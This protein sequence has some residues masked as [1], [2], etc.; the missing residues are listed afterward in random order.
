MRAVSVSRRSGTSHRDEVDLLTEVESI[1]QLVADHRVVAKNG[2]VGW[3]GPVGYGTT[4]KPLDVKPL[5][6]HLYHGTLGV[7]VFL[8]AASRVLERDDFATLAVRAVA[9]LGDKLSQL[10]RD[11][12]WPQS[13]RTPVGG[14][15]GLGSFVYG[16]LLLGRLLRSDDLIRQARLAATLITPEA[17]ARDERVWVQVGS[18]G[19]ALALLA[20]DREDPAP[21]VE[22][23]ASPLE[24]ARACGRQIL[25]QRISFGGRP[26]AWCLSPG[27]PPLIGFAYGAAGVCFAL[28]RLYERL[29]N[30]E[31]MAAA[32]EGWSFLDQLY[33]PRHAGWQDMRALVQ[34]DFSG[35]GSNDLVEWWTSSDSAATAEGV[36]ESAEAGGRSCFTRMWC[37]G[38]SGIAMARVATLDP[39]RVK[40]DGESAELRRVL[41]SLTAPIPDEEAGGGTRADDVCCGYMGR[42]EA[43]LTAARTLDRPEYEDHARHLAGAVVRRARRRRCYRLTATR[44]RDVFSPS[45]FQG[46]SGIGYTLLRLTDPE[47]IPSLC[48]FE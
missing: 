19:A 16:F 33:S 22:G 46:I 21:A 9:P 47:S 27:K 31:L 43:L 29:G 35:P 12:A 25:R 10:A 23:A 32:R 3:L 6:P 42:V 37:H 44:G 18:A 7:A 40:E 24:L 2:T 17:I 28:T 4:G 45:F 8:A 5:G 48:L 36:P 41:E 39:V 30:D 15:I 20:L 34:P 14:L 26:R 13:L 38:G 1:A 11:P